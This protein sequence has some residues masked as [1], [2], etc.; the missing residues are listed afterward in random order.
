MEELLKE[1]Y[2][3]IIICL[4]VISVLLFLVVLVDQ[5]YIKKEMSDEIKELKSELQKWKN[6]Y[7]KNVSPYQKQQPY[8]QH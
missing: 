8:F 7:N 4:S 5:L 6:W 3:L 2:L 1:N